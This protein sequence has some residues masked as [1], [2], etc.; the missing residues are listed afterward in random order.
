MPLQKGSS[1][2]VI[3]DNIRTEINS[4][5]KQS[6]AVAIALHTAGRA[7]RA[8]GGANNPSTLSPPWYVRSEARSMGRTGAL[9]GST[10]GRADKLPISVPS[11]SHVIPADVVGHLGQGNTA[12]GM[13]GMNNMFGTSQLGVKP[14]PIKAMGRAPHIAGPKPMNF[15][16]GGA[17]G[18]P[19][20]IMASDGEFV[21]SPE[22]VMEIGGGD[23]ER[24]HKIIDKFILNERA[25]HIK[26]LKKLPPPAKS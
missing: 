22:K 17:I 25:K 19:V 15:A 3:S 26:T 7:R 12:A 6:Q 21:V 5:K 9:T 16:K 2:A 10:G 20:P 24:G 23:L 18:K 8:A 1:R 14:L 13:V 11:G 4:G